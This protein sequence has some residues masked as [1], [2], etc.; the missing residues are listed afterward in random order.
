MVRVGFIGT[1]GIAQ[2]HLSKLANIKDV[3]YAAVCDL[4]QEKARNTAEKLGCPWYKDYREMLKKEKMDA[5]YICIPPFAHE[6]QEI[7]ACNKGIHIF[8]EKPTALS[9]EKAKRVIA[10]IKKNRIISAVGHQDR[11][12]D[13]VDRLKEL[14]KGRKVGMVI[15]Y[16]M[17]G[18]PM[19]YWWR[20]KKLSGGQIVEQTIHVFDM[21]RYIFGEV[22]EVYA[23]GTKGIM[24]AKVERCDIE[25]ASAVTL[26]MKSGLVITIFSANFLE[27]PGRV[28]LDIFAEGLYIEY[29]ER[30]SLRVVGQGQDQTFPLGNDTG[31]VCDQ[32]FIE[33]VKT[34]DASRIRSTYE[35]AAKSLAVTLAAN[36]SLAMGKPV[37]L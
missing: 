10:A 11:Y 4:D 3:E 32:T 2:F 35:D 6:D 5:C 8:V 1:G 29:K 34:G 13:N 16:W 21:A 27:Y 12:E 31:L 28:G 14:L 18:F 25:D 23:A 30:N 22:E 9:M 7:M 26:K 24:S 20:E 33:A 37:R 17:G 19:V 36:R 15:G